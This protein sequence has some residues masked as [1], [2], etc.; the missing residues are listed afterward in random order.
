MKLSSHLI[1]EEQYLLLAQSRGQWLKRLRIHF[2]A[3]WNASSWLHISFRKRP[4]TIQGYGAQF[5]KVYMSSCQEP[6]MCLK[7]WIVRNTAGKLTQMVNMNNNCLNKHLQFPFTL[8]EAKALQ[9]STQEQFS[10]FLFN[11]IGLFI[12]FLIHLVPSPAT[13]PSVQHSGRVIKNKGDLKNRKM[14]GR[15]RQKLGKQIPHI[16]ILHQIV[17]KGGVQVSVIRITFSVLENLQKFELY[18]LRD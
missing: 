13:F 5:F 16:A 17:G 11:L 1:Q 14:K 3:P 15:Y 7:E 18:H 4:Q 10:K 2:K 6:N 9:K 8:L 12:P